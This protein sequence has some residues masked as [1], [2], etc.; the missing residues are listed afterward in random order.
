MRGVFTLTLDF[1]GAAN[2]FPGNFVRFLEIGVRPAGTSG[3]YEFLT[4][5][6]P[7][8]PVPYALRADSVTSGAIVGDSIGPG[9][10][11][12]AKLANNAIA[13][14]KLADSAVS[15]AKL[16]TNAVTNAKVLPGS[17][18]MNRHAGV[19]ANGSL[20]ALTLGGNSCFTFELS[21]GGA[22]AG[23]FPLIALQAGAVLPANMSLTALRVPSNGIVQYRVC[24]HGA[25]TASWS[26][27]AVI[28]MTLR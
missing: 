16:A 12:T 20:G 7:I 22:Q 26:S 6:T 2:P 17:L 19:F 4:P 1:S 27:L 18:T 28:F 5:L 13:S 8:H 24:N 3:A 14:A 15:N 11:T 9:A 23:D 10:V 21:N 25:I